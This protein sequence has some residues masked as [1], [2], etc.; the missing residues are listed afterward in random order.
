MAGGS[1]NNLIATESSELQQGHYPE[2]R[3][4]GFTDCDGTIAFY[5]RVQALLPDRGTV[6][7]IGCGLGNQCQDRVELRRRIRDLRSGTRQVIGL[8]VDPRA[9]RNPTIDTFRLVAEDGR[10]PLQTGS[11]DLA[12]ADY[13]LEHVRD[14]EHFLKEC[15]RVLRPGGYVCIRTPNVASYFGLVSFLTPHS[16]RK[17][18][19]QAVQS[20]RSPDEIY[21]TFYRCN[22]L[23][24]LRRLLSAAGFS[25]CVY[26]YEA[27]PSYLSFSS[28]AYALGVVHQRVAPGFLRVG[29]FAY[30]SKQ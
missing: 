29:L 16:V 7:D 11:A 3:F 12:V 17:R 6:L 9:Q 8:D 30:G 23:W 5:T 10:W 4:G 24:R 20:A 28:L 26:G 15:A 27:E 25:A 21:P 13:V 22:T 19:V 14:P 18:V 1:R 2:T